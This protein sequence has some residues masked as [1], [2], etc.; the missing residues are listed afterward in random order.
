MAA[1]WESSQT[2]AHTFYGTA[3]FVQYCHWDTSVVS[4]KNIIVPTEVSTTQAESI[5]AAVFALTNPNT[6][7]YYGTYDLFDSTTSSPN[8]NT[9]SL[10]QTTL[11]TR[12]NTIASTGAPRYIINP[13]FYSLTTKGYP[14]QYVTG[15]VPVYWTGSGIGTSGD[16]VDVNGDSYTFFNAG[17][18]FGLILKTS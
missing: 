14:T 5:M 1:V 4:R 13:V 9:G 6:G 8:L 3:P 15:I 10:A 11:G 17:T 16:I 7:T 12:V 18:G 2:E